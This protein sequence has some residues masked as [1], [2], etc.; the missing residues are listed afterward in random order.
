MKVS[1]HSYLLIA[2]DK[3]TLYYIVYVPSVLTT[4]TS[5]SHLS[6]IS[7]SSLIVSDGQIHFDDINMDKNYN[8]WQAYGQSKLA[9]VL[10]T[11]SLY[12]K[13]HGKYLSNKCMV[14]L[15]V[16]IQDISN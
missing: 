12:R 6:H 5:I 8:A 14:S 16:S 1:I 3:T 13:Y 15:P 7:T 10:F 2:H 9:N 4:S 11:R